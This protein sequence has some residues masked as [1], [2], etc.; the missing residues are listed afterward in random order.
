VI[1]IDKIVSMWQIDGMKTGTRLLTEEDINQLKAIDEKEKFFNKLEEIGKRE[2]ARRP[3]EKI[4][5]ADV[6]GEF[7]QYDGSGLTLEEG[8][9]RP[10][11]ARCG[12]RP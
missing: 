4:S 7:S 11:K 8:F 5:M 6:H 3:G 12:D 9:A 2:A 1:F 10:A